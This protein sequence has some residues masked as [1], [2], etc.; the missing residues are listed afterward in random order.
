MKNP[1]EFI[2]EYN[3]VDENGDRWTYFEIREGC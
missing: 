2:E 3:L 1:Q